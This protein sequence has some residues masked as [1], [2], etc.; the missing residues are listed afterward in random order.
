MNHS[1]T[2]VQSGA[3]DPSRLRHAGPPLGLVAT[4]YTVLFLAGLYPVTMFGG[5]PYYPG[6]WESAD[7]IAAFFQ[8]R[9][10]AVRVCA[11]LQFGAAIPLGIF[12]ASIVSRLQFLGARVAGVSIA[13][14]G[15]IATA[16]TIMVAS[17][18]LWVMS[19]PG[20]AENRAV[21]QALY[22]LA[23]GFGGAGFSVP[24]GILVA[25]VTIP[26]AF[27]RLIP[28]W[29]VILGIA[30]AICGEL[31]CL[32]LMV[33]GALPLIPLARFP[34]FVWMIAIGFVL[35]SSI[36]RASSTAETRT[37]RGM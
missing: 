7:T 36:A 31:S 35:P 24:F 30:V 5:H 26:A 16:V 32:Y 33:P 19:Q 14:F 17:T 25:G 29:I 21:L 3:R 15:G 9:P 11:F 34:G 12:A 2:E 10:T 4:I 6:P 18:A 37:G 1:S 22:W 20:I 23:Q 28:K 8:A 13:L 27:M